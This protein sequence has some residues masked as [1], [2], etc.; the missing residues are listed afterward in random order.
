[1]L[2]Q[3]AAAADAEEQAAAAQVVEHA[4]FFIKPKRMVERQH[5]NERPESQCRRAREGARQ[6]HAR[7][8]GKPERR[9]VML[10]EVIAVKAAALDNLN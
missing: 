10:G 4:D 6:E 7:A 5:V 3:R 8:A 9:R 2:D 1:M